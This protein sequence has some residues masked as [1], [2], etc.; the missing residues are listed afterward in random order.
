MTLTQEDRDKA[1]KAFK[2]LDAKVK[3]MEDT[4]L[5]QEKQ[6]LRTI[7]DDF[8][9]DAITN[10]ATKTD[11]TQAQSSIS[12]STIRTKYDAPVAFNGKREDWKPFKSRLHFYFLKNKS[13]TDTNKIHYAISRLGDT[14]TFKY[15]QR[16]ADDFDKPIAERPMIISQYTT[17]LSSLGQAFG[18]VNA[19][20]VS[21]ANLRNLKQRG[22]AQ[23]YILKHGISMLSP[24][25]RS[26]MP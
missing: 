15:M 20:L 22:S 26:T 23:D 2:A 7:F 19:H 8:R 3:T 4:L 11:I 21:E 12:T 9:R 24:L 1:N 17:F 5:Q 25:A 14:A 10:F 6:E 13:L 18:V 16:Y